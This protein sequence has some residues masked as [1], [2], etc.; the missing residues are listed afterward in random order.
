MLTSLA[1]SQVRGQ[2]CHP[3]TTQWVRSW[4]SSSRILTKSQGP[5]LQA[6][7]YAYLSGTPT[8]GPRSVPVSTHWGWVFM[9]P[10]PCCGCNHRTI[11]HSICFCSNSTFC[12]LISLATLIFWITSIVLLM[13]IMGSR[14]LTPFYSL[15]LLFKC[16]AVAEYIRKWELFWKVVP[17]HSALF[18]MWKIFNCM[19][20]RM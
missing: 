18:S 4:E 3:P 11:R 14:C 15:Y 17:T 7:R 9:N 1:N 8:W 16:A 5:G 12:F 10:C 20:W 6:S 19:D 2:T 13:V